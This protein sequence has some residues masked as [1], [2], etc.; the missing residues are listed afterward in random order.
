MIRYVEDGF[1]PIDNNELN[2][3]SN[4]WPLAKRTGSSP[5]IPMVLMSMRYYTASSRQQKLTG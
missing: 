4:R 5:I 2:A 1:L 3:L